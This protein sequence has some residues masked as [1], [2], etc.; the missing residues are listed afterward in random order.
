MMDDCLYRC[1]NCKRKCETTEER[2]WIPFEAWG[3]AD[4][5]SNFIIVSACCG[6]TV[7][8]LSEE[9]EEE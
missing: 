5:H 1:D 8:L 2:E 9:S 3:H 6:T 4:I 7:G